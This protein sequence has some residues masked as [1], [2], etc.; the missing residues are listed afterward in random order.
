MSLNLKADLQCTS[1]SHNGLRCVLFGG[2]DIQKVA[3]R[4]YTQDGRTLYWVPRPQK[5][6]APIVKPAPKVTVESAVLVQPDG[7]RYEF[8]W[9]TPLESSV[10]STPSSGS[11]RGVI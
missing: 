6:E 7:S 4:A 8:R 9:I 10:T 11:V 1:V 3:H 2:H 5:N